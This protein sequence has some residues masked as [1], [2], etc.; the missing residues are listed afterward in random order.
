VPLWDVK[1]LQKKMFQGHLTPEIEKNFLTASK[2]KKIL[3]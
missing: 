1:N 3:A 2:A